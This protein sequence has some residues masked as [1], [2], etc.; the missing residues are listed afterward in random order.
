VTFSSRSH[1]EYFQSWLPQALEEGQ[2][3]ILKDVVKLTKAA[4]VDGYEGLAP[5][6]AIKQV[7]VLAVGVGASA[8]GVGA[9]AVGRVA[10][11]AMGVTVGVTHGVVAGAGHLQRAAGDVVVDTFMM[12]HSTAN[13]AGGVGD[14][15]STVGVGEG[16]GEASVVAADEEQQ[17]N[18]YLPPPTV[19]APVAFASA[20]R[21]GRH[22]SDAMQP[23]QQQQQRFGRHGSDAMQSAWSSRSAGETLEDT[24][25]GRK[26][27]DSASRAETHSMDAARVESLSRVP[28]AASRQRASSIGTSS[29][30]PIRVLIKN[31]T[32]GVG[33]HG[34]DAMEMRARSGTT[35]WG[36][37]ARSASTADSPRKKHHRSRSQEAG[38]RNMDFL[39]L[40]REH[41][42]SQ[43]RFSDDSSSDSSGDESVADSD[44]MPD[45]VGGL[46]KF[47]SSEDGAAA[48][49][50]AAAAAEKS[51]KM[52][53]RE[54]RKE[55]RLR[56]L[57]LYK[58][59]EKDRVQQM[60]LW[61]RYRTGELDTNKFAAAA[62]GSTNKNLT[63]AA[64]RVRRASSKEHR[65]KSRRYDSPGGMRPEAVD[66]RSGTVVRPPLHAS[67]LS[68]DWAAWNRSA[69]N[70]EHD[71]QD[72]H[73]ESH[74]G[75]EYQLA[76]EKEE[77]EFERRR[78]K[79][80]HTQQKK[81]K[82]AAKKV[83]R[84]RKKEL[85]AAQA[86]G[87]HSK[88]FWE[89]WRS[90]NTSSDSGGSL[91]SR[92]S[93]AASSMAAS[94]GA[95][96]SS[97][98]NSADLEQGD[99]GQVVEEGGQVGSAA[100]GTHKTVTFGAPREAPQYAV[101]QGGM[102]EVPSSPQSTTTNTSSNTDE[103]GSDHVGNVFDLGVN[104][105]KVHRWVIGKAPEPGEIVWLPFIQTRGRRQTLLQKM[106]IAIVG[107]VV[108]V[109]FASPTMLASGF[110]HLQMLTD[111]G[112]DGNEGGGQTQQST[113]VPSFIL[114]LQGADVGPFVTALATWLPAI[115]TNVMN[116]LILF[117][118]FHLSWSYDSTHKSVSGRMRNVLVAAFF[119]LV[120]NTMIVPV[121]GS[122]G[123]I[124]VFNSDFWNSDSIQ[125][126]II[127]LTSMTLVS[128]AIQLACT[129]NGLSFLCTGQTSAMQPWL[130]SRAVTAREVREAEAM[131]PMYYGWELS[132]VVLM[133][134]VGVAPS[135]LVPVVPPFAFFYFIIKF[136]VD[137]YNI[138][139]VV[140]A[141]AS[142]SQGKVVLTS[143]Q[144]IA[145]VLLAT[146]LLVFAMVFA[147]EVEVA[148]GTYRVAR[149]LG[150]PPVYMSLAL[151]C[152]TALLVVMFSYNF[153]VHKLMNVVERDSTFQFERFA[154]SQF[155]T[156]GIIARTLD[157]ISS[158]FNGC[159]L[160]EV[161]ER[162]SFW[163]PRE[164]FKSVWAPFHGLRPSGGT[165]QSSLHHNNPRGLE[166]MLRAC[167]RYR[168][169]EEGIIDAHGRRRLPLSTMAHVPAF[170]AHRDGYDWVYED[171]E[172]GLLDVKPL[173]T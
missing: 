94:G 22:G 124:V 11:V 116:Y 6:N 82:K 63:A 135:A 10:N 108:L 2:K 138:L 80:L 81:N 29:V 58:A 34:S 123:V 105:V 130:R 143:L 78:L 160:P 48:A 151:L 98:D 90:A 61:W 150:A 57:A 60:K 31:R 71:Q 24:F 156:K 159:K 41:S 97:R 157:C 86:G 49:A 20:Q 36:R 26:R 100:A 44:Y 37:A 67:G 110:N 170:Y 17:R 120:L 158:I 62:A 111:D 12:R 172:H 46:R 173:R 144:L 103:W 42:L 161:G 32:Q 137:K 148:T 70:L 56:E 163:F 102:G 53:R 89:K 141:H 16:V 134:A 136:Y 140:P 5:K 23:L 1:L 122:A 84:Q 152:G 154:W 91:A 168:I 88:M 25:D 75:E 101:S 40:S 72:H 64:L 109:V 117:M 28:N 115:Y 107:L 145:V 8:V 21:F 112:G 162:A 132:S 113:S 114:D 83:K 55:R 165:K 128:F 133:A 129:S 164:Q 18:A 87:E 13:A 127:T 27:S 118:L 43:D 104:T 33:R 45:M 99:A 95:A 167:G 125:P 50:T 66:A 92:L 7:G 166:Y 68:S 93:S 14:E 171:D 4:D 30:S 35:G 155:M 77:R 142:N 47:I 79:K 121:L 139:Y 3:L 65:K 38:S 147:R 76:S 96:N 106:V 9:S 19:A 169:P 85:K 131:W 52:K 126:F 69:E 51:A 119:F 15:D 39:G 153:N 146:Q 59:E 74:L 73:L 149:A 54:A